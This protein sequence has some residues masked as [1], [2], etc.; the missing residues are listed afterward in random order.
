MKYEELAKEIIAGVGGEDNVKSVFHCV[1]RLRFKL[2]NESKAQTEKLKGLDGIVTVMQSGGQYQVVIGN[3]VDEV[4]NAVVKAGNIKTESMDI[5]DAEPSGN[6]FDRFIDLI[7]GIFTP[8]LGVLAATGMIK[9]LVAL[10]VSMNVLVDGQNTFIILNAAGDAMFN[11]L[12]I[13]LGYNAAKKFR[14]NPF[15]AMTIAA[16]M[17]YPSIAGLS[18]LAMAGAGAEPLY[19]LFSGTLFEAPVYITFLGLPVI[20]MSY[21]SS[22]IPII[23]SVYVSSKV[24]RFFTK[25]IPSVVRTFLVPF[26]V[27]LVMVPLTF[28]IIGP[29]ATW[30]GNLL[31]AL[32]EL[33]YNFSPVVTGVFIGAFWQ[34]FVIFGLHWGLIP[35]MMSN[36]Q[37]LGYDMIVVLSF[38]CSFAQTGAV[39]AV[40]LKTKNKKT[41]SL[42]IPAFISGI[43]GVTEPA[44]YGVTLPLKR[45]F[46]ASC[47]AGAVGGGILGLLGTKS[48]INGGLGIFAF[49]N[50]LNVETGMDMAFYGSFIAAGVGL[51][52]GFI[53][54]YMIGFKED[55]TEPEL[56]SAGGPN[57]RSVMPEVEAAVVPSQVEA[58][59]AVIL[60]PLDG[61]LSPLSEIDDEVF[62]SGAMGQGLAITPTKGE[63]RSPVT[64]RVTTIFPTGHA[65]GLT[66]DEG[67]EVLLHIGMDTVELKGQGFEA[68]VK[69]GETVGAGDLL[70]RF[71][72]D[73]IK[74]EGYSVVTPVVITNGADYRVE[75]TTATTATTGQSL[76]TIKD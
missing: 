28:L 37:V 59:D 52:L 31:G 50:Y 20:M 58:V 4:F 21:A 27:I 7:S 24:E 19:T 41:K 66:S 3:H 47:A 40:Y 12:P 34:V 32:T 38:A 17:I 44:I 45:P 8:T 16:A 43:F 25:V 57:Q 1:T 71:D 64:G 69:S 23:I 11:A 29:V 53:F 9:G 18:P 39:A 70:V 46:Y 72:I 15:I 49:P 55:L 67:V 36:L 35:I 33:L 60:S 26:C 54:A 10:L 48:Y 68:F 73:K 13:F 61:T 56:V 65:V 75:L 74:A 6:L 62:S 30:A 76:I 42:A 63:L 22:V 51:V 2:E 5:S 14:S